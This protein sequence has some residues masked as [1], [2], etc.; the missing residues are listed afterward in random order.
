MSSHNFDRCK[1]CDQYDFLDQHRCP[2]A[3]RIW[4]DGYHDAD[5]ELD[6][7]EVHAAD[8]QDAARDGV[9][10]WDACERDLLRG[11]VDVLVRP[12]GTGAGPGE[13]FTVS[14]EAVIEY[15]AMPCERPPVGGQP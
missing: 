7:R 10:R 2:P 3:W 4:I 8:A 5:D 12:A 1:A 9:E 13:W 14:A 11:A 15:R 6:G